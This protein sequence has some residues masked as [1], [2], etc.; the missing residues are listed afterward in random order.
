MQ[1]LLFDLN[2]GTEPRQR[3]NT[4][5]KGR[6]DC[7]GGDEWKACVLQRWRARTGAEEGTG[8]SDWCV[9]PQTGLFQDVLWAP[10][11]FGWKEQARFALAWVQLGCGFKSPHWTTWCPGPQPQS[12]C[13]LIQYRKH[14]KDLIPFYSC[15]SSLKWLVVQMRWC[16]KYT[17]EWHVIPL[18]LSAWSKPAAKRLS[19]RPSDVL[20]IMTHLKFSL[21]K[22]KTK[23][24]SFCSDY[25]KLCRF[26]HR[27]LFNRTQ[28]TVDHFRLPWASPSC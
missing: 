7:A 5:H 27:S 18:V 4:S 11:M 23:K 13:R 2:V 9:S 17:T 26:N 19:E 25:S 20:S 28:P 10:Q 22:I 12:C 8:G 16:F 15:I 14:K 3:H 21:V 24:L 1:Q 6:T